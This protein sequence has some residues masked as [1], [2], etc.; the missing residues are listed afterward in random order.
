M[1][2]LSVFTHMRD[3]RETELRDRAKSLGF[4]L[5]PGE[6]GH[7]YVLA[8]RLP[9]RRREPI[10]GGNGGVPID[11]IEEWLDKQERVGPSGT[12]KLRRD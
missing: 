1:E 3:K 9:G 7:M 12:L 10:V 11:T 6:I 5:Y 8:R 2:P 4:D